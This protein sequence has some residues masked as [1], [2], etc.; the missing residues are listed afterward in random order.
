MVYC[1]AYNKHG[2][3]LEENRRLTRSAF[4]NAIKALKYDPDFPERL[5]ISGKVLEEH[6]LDIH[7]WPLTPGH[8]AGIIIGGLVVLAGITALLIVLVRLCNKSRNSS[9]PA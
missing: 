3:S 5:A 1:W 4:E 8:I 2:F 7:C 6:H 9:Y